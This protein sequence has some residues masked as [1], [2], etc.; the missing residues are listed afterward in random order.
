MILGVGIDAV[1]I[2][3]FQVWAQYSRTRLRSLFSDEELDYCLSNPKKSAERLAVRFAAREAL[4][5]ALSPLA[6]KPLSLL[7]VCRAVSIFVDERG[8]HVN[9]ND[10]WLSRH[11]IQEDLRVHV[12]L[13]HTNN[14]AAAVII[15]E[16]F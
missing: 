10:Q 9:I 2:E 1:E 13:T 12:S 3:R 6:K 16:A 4:L 7:S 14:T 5:K 11:G 15:V 8:V